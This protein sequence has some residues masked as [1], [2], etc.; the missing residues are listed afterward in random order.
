MHFLLLNF[1]V[2]K[3]QLEDFSNRMGEKYREIFCLDV[4][5]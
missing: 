3:K 5:P 4:S 2:K 1:S